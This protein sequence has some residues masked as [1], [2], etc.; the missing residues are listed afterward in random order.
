MIIKCFSTLDKDED[1]KLFDQKN[2]NAI[3]NGIKVHDVQLMADTS[4]ISGK[5]LRHVIMVYAYLSRE[6]AWIHG[7][8]QV[9]GQTNHRKIR[10]I[11]STDSSGHGR[12]RLVIADVDAD[13]DLEEVEEE[14]AE[15]VAVV[16]E[17][18]EECLTSTALTSPTPLAHLP[19]K[20]GPRLVQAVGEPMS[21][22][23]A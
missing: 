8:A 4:Y 18:V 7:S 11:Y 1:E 14:A 21:L 17:I 16:A 3:I 23:N 12:G 20:N 2:V 19:T 9:S 13:K 5:Y 15:L 6:V 22:N 10:G